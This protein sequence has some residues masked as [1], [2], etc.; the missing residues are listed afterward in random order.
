MENTI[1][2]STKKDEKFKVFYSNIT[3]NFPSTGSL[4]PLSEESFL[5]LYFVVLLSRAWAN[6]R[7]DRHKST[8]SR[9]IGLTQYKG[10]LVC[11]E[12]TLKRS[13][14][15][16]PFK[17]KCRPALYFLLASRSFC[18]CHK[19]DESLTW[20]AY[21][22]HY[23][24]FECSSQIRILKA[25]RTYFERNSVTLTVFISDDTAH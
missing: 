9:T 19:R 3:V 22:C 20:C 2:I 15:F 7:A 10:K 1:D 5:S 17:A 16:F 23:F 13:F 8:N 4:I 14:A 18:I 25:R 11:L 21:F 6:H 12:L 24:L